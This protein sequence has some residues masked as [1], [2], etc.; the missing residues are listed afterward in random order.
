MEYIAVSRSVRI[1]PRKIGL[2]AGAIRKKSSIKDSLNTLAVIRKR[3]AIPVLKTL[4]SAVA[5]AINKGAK[6]E[7]LILE[8]ITVSQGSFFKRYR[9]ST[10]GR[11]HPY[12]KRSSHI[13]IVLTDDKGSKRKTQSAEEMM[14][15]VTHGSEN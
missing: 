15:G 8:S 14:K 1:S 7:N 4:E 5:N 10:R 13:R 2:V 12:K 9:P 11:V 6:K 3:S